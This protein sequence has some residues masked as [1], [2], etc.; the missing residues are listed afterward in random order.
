M[1]RAAAFV[2]EHDNQ[3]GAQVR[4][5][6]FDAAQGV[7]AREI[8]GDADDKQIADMLVEDQFRRGARV[9]AADD[10]GKGVLGLGGLG[11]PDGFGFAVGG[12]AADEALV[13]GL[14]DGQGGVR[15][16]GLDWLGGEESGGGGQAGEEDA[17]QIHWFR[18]AADSMGR[19]LRSHLSAS[20]ISHLWEAAK[21]PAFINGIRELFKAHVCNREIVFYGRDVH[22]ECAKLAPPLFEQIHD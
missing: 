3:A 15:A 17:G 20:C 6:V 16:D 1:D 8:A 13:A 7:L 2:A 21:H 18:I 5:G 9:R 4:D 11:P 12:F 19:S 14:E 22:G 10:D